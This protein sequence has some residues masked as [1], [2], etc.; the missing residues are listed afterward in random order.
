MYPR[1][2]PL[3]HTH[4][5]TIVLSHIK[6]AISIDTQTMWPWIIQTTS[7][8]INVTVHH[9]GHI[10]VSEQSNHRVQ[11]LNADLTYS[12][13][14]GSKGAQ[15]GEFNT[16]RG[17][18]IDAGGM[19]YVADCYNNRVQK[20]TPEGKLLAVIN[21]KGGRLNDPWPHGLCVDANGILYVTEYNSSRVSMR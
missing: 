5:T 6:Y 18:A 13:C 21:I 10:F 12:H 8:K 16:P 1:N 2:L 20:F 14:F 17:I 9:N 19:V 4:S 15:L 11:V 3:P 7:N